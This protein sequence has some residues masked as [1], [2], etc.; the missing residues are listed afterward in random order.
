MHNLCLVYF[1]NLY[2]F[3]AYLGPSSGSTTVCIQQMVLILFRWLSV[4]LVGLAVCCP[5]W[6]V[7]VILFRWLL[8]WLDWLSVVLVGLAVWCPG[9]IVP[10]IPFRW[11]SLLLVRLFQSYQDNRQPSKKN[12]K[13]QFL[14]T[15]GCTSWWWTI[16]TPETCRGWRNILRISCSSNWFFF[17]HVILRNIAFDIHKNHILLVH[18]FLVCSVFMKSYTVF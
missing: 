13:Y 1:V 8:S 5:G 7:P 18:K 4:V 11:L 15:Y 2:L 10:I 3:R 14:Y 6:I 12:N 16:D 9:W 17:I